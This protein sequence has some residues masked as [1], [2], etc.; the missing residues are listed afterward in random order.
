MSEKKKHTIVN[1]KGEDITQAHDA[2]KK[3][4]EKPT[5]VRSQNAFNRLVLACKRLMTVV[6]KCEG[7]TNK[8]LA[9]FEGQIQNLVDKWDIK[10]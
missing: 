6:M 9:K 3:K 2:A 1:T 5:Q 8:D 7:M 10:E 4:A